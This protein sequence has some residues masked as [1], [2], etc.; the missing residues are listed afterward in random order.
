MVIWWH[1][2]LAGPP[3]DV[4]TESLLSRRP[5]DHRLEVP[6]ATCVGLPAQATNTQ[7]LFRTIRG[8]TP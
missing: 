8:W 6:V 5:T 1:E 4:V 7:R 2:R 3:S